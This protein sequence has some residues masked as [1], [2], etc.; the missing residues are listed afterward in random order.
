[1]DTKSSSFSVILK[2]TFYL[3]FYVVVLLFFVVLS[4][5]RDMSDGI[6]TSAAFDS[7]PVIVIDAGHGGFDGGATGISGTV[8]KELNLQIAKY[9]SSLL[10]LSNIDYVMTRSDDSE[11]IFSGKQSLT[12]KLSDLLARVEIANNYKDCYFISI[13]QNK[14]PSSKYRG[15]QVFYSK[16]AVESRNFAQIIK[17]NNQ[18]LVDSSNKREIKPAG[19]EIYILDKIKSPAVLVECGFLSN[20]QEEKLLSSSDYQKRIAF[21]LYCSIVE[22]IEENYNISKGKI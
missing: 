4:T 5:S 3:A 16:N 15:L 21:M 2:I 17:I 11:L 19:K 1:M 7:A 12:R 8:E 18:T 20:S 14:F 6:F 13:H 22:F 10:K 9:L